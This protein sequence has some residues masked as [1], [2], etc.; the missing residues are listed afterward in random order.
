MK[1]LEEDLHLQELIHKIKKKQ[2]MLEV[3]DADTFEEI[4]V[5]GIL[6]DNLAVAKQD[7]KEWLMKL[8]RERNGGW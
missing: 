8:Y 1:N 7:Y 2:L 5:K 3:F 4:E 6:L